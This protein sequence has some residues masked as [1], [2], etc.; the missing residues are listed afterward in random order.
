MVGIVSWGGD[1]LVE[2]YSLMP[3]ICCLIFWLVFLIVIIE[4]PHISAPRY[5]EANN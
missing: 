5:S 4:T 2:G 3:E 1:T